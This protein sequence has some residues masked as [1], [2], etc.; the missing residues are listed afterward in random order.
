MSQL[1]AMLGATAGSSAIKT[2][3]DDVF[4]TLLYS[5][6]GTSTFKFL[7]TIS[8]ENT[9]AWNWGNTQMVYNK[10]IAAAASYL[11]FGLTDGT[12][13]GVIRKVDNNLA[14][15]AIR[16]FVSSGGLTGY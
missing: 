16:T 9:D 1:L 11:L 5:G 13:N 12:T 15:I 14:D 7:D 8:Y 6:G 4:Q 2:Y 3:V 10:G